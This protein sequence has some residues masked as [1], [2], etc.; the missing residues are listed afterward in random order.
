MLRWKEL[1]NAHN[2]EDIF[3]KPKLLLLKRMNNSCYWVLRK[4]FRLET[5]FLT[6]TAVYRDSFQFLKNMHMYIEK[7]QIWIFNITREHAP[8]YL[9][10]QLW[11]R[12]NI[13]TQRMILAKL[14]IGPIKTVVDLI[15]DNYSR[16]KQKDNGSKCHIIQPFDLIKT[17]RTIVSFSFF[18]IFPVGHQQYTWN[19]QDSKSGYATH[20][21]VYCVI[22]SVDNKSTYFF[23]FY[24]IHTYA[25]TQIFNFKWSWKLQELYINKIIKL[26][27]MMKEQE[28]N[29]IN[30]ILIF[31]IETVLKILLRNKT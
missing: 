6:E 7:I 14:K 11:V 29:V 5:L 27:H 12:Y 9:N 21:C 3:R 10:H 8:W 4:I 15:N 23:A 24:N 26:W 31:L 18:L 1:W 13:N 28:N 19:T 16:T 17:C 30:D 22:V 25:Y 2:R 20:E